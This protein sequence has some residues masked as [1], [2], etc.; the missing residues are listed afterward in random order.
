MLKITGIKLQKISNI[1]MHL[2]TE[3]G[4]RGGISYISKRYSKSDD[5]TIM[6]W[7]AN[8]LYG[9]AMIQSLF[10]CD[11][12]WLSN[13]EINNFSLNISENS[14]IGYILECDLEYCKEL[15]IYAMIILG[16]LNSG[17]MSDYCSDIANWY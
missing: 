11:F 10:V 13:K 1:V 9:W 6:Y 2:V 17:M 7:N 14:P 15:Q 5:K 3:K 12:K 4:M 8:N 16:A